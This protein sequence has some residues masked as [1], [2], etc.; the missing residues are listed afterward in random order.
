[1]AIKSSKDF[2]KRR[3]ERE[4]NNEIEDSKFKVLCP[5]CKRTKNNGLS[6]IGMCVAD[7]DY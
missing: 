6:C 2:E 5:Y 4:L 7:N 1:M 3:L